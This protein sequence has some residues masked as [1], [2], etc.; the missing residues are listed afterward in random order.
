MKKVILRFLRIITR[1]FSPNNTL[2]LNKKKV[3]KLFKSIKFN[4]ETLK[5]QG[6]DISYNI[7]NEFMVLSINDRKYV[8]NEFGYEFL[9]C[10]DVGE[11][12]KLIPKEQ[13]FKD[14][15]VIYKLNKNKEYI[16]NG[17]YFKVVNEDLKMLEGVLLK[18][19]IFDDWVKNYKC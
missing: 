19:K 8:L 18:N 13:K 6:F 12:S 1:I 2:N 10:F 9:I 7:F 14:Y 11:K 16:K 5:E 15:V 4:T 3:G 17:S